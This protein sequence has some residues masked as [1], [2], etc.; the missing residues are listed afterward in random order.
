[1]NWRRSRRC[2]PPRL[3][4]AGPGRGP[5]RRPPPRESRKMSAAERKAVSERMTAYW[6]ERRKAEVGSLALDDGG[7]VP[8]DRHS[9]LWQKS[10]RSEST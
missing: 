8:G 3:A 10:D 9:S 1:M 7:P 6:A 4:G 2:R 5:T